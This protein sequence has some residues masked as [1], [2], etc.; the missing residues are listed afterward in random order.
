MVKDCYLYNKCNHVDCNNQFCL[1]KYKMDSLYNESLL[2][3]AQKKHIALRVDT[4]GT[5]FEEFKKLAALEQN[6]IKFVEAGA[7]LYL[8]STNCGNGKTSWSIRMISSYFDKIWA[9]TEPGCRAL[10][11]NVPKLFIDLKASINKKIP[12]IDKI[13]ENILKADLV[14][15]DDIAT[16]ACSDYE[17]DQLTKMVNDRINAGKANI[18]TSNIAPGLLKDIVAERLASRIANSSMIIELHG[19]DKRF[20]GI[21]TLEEE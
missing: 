21:F 17:I 13:Q 2:T 18:F 14:V 3:E 11:I 16:K 9:K 19:A 20:L 1:R 12:Y 4:D 8:F 15:W 7:N 5:D 10:F 6:I